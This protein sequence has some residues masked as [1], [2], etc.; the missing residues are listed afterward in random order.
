MDLQW[1]IRVYTGNMSYMRTPAESRRAAR[2]K[3]VAGRVEEAGPSEDGE[4]GR[5]GKISIPLNIPNII[6]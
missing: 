4:M 6:K 1:V 5:A 3:I 2:F